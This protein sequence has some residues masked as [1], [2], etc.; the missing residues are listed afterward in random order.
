MFFESSAKNGSNVF[1][2]MHDMASLLREKEDK[3]IEN[4]VVLA[5]EAN[6]KKGCCS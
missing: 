1:Q 5:D 3:Q 2:T 4:A 6:K